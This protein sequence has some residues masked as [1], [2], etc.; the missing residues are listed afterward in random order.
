[1]R[2]SSDRRTSHTPCRKRARRERLR[3]VITEWHLGS[4]SE[5]DPFAKPVHEP[6]LVD[7]ACRNGEHRFDGVIGVGVLVVP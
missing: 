5:G 4:G 1:M 3:S 2:Y 7:L 6:G